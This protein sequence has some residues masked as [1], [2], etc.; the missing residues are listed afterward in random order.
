VPWSWPDVPGGIDLLVC[1][2][3]TSSSGGGPLEEPLYDFVR[4]FNVDLVSPYA[5][6]QA[7]GRHM[8]ERGSGT[9]VTLRPVRTRDR[10]RA[11]RLQNRSG[12]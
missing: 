8:A 6:C 4:L 5:L 9:I 10:R 11:Q 1:S 3:G 7:A 12:Q 2:A